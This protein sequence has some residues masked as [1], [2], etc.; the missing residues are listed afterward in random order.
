MKPQ[1]VH[2][3][4][5]RYRVSLPAQVY[6]LRLLARLR[7]S[8]RLRWGMAVLLLAGGLGGWLARPAQQ[9]GTGQLAVASV[10]QA[11]AQLGELRIL[12]LSASQPGRVQWLA[13]PVGARVAAGEV[14][15]RLYSAQLDQARQQAEAALA[16]AR[17][18]QDEAQA[19]LEHATRQLAQA[20]ARLR[21]S[22]RGAE[23]ALAQ[24][25]A[26]LTRA[27]ASEQ[28][29]HI[30][31]QQAETAV[32]HAAQAL[33]AT[34]VRAPVAGWVQQRHRQAGSAIP[35][36]AS[37]A[38]RALFSLVDAASLQLRVSLSA[39]ELARA[40][41]G[42]ACAV[43]FAAL[44]GQVF[45]GEVLR[46][47]PPQTL[48]IQLQQYH[49]QLRSALPALVAGLPHPQREKTAPGAQAH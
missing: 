44:P 9:A 31:I 35:P 42:Q 43:Q 37:D 39:S 12:T 40:Q 21:H 38:Q 45:A 29:G 14:L 47:L 3:L 49:P 27:K 25:E 24:A 30:A 28:A 13:G 10:W 48:V 23:A 26:Q 33:E 34:L 17:A 20:H 22:A 15:A 16:H 32:L 5:N 11:S 46:I 19:E 41:P 36:A 6:L 2:V 18:G 4:P 1:A 8:S 7:R